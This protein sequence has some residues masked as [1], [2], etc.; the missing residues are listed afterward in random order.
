M[1]RTCSQRPSNPADTLIVASYLLVISGR[2][3]LGHG[4]LLQHSLG[5]MNGTVELRRIQ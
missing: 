1:V 4:E 3:D 2:S 5:R